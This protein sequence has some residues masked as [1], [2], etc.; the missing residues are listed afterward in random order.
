M[1][2]I[3]RR[4][5]TTFV[6]YRVTAPPLVHVVLGLMFGLLHWRRRLAIHR[7]AWRIAQLRAVRCLGPVVLRTLELSVSG[8]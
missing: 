8:E 6:A 3:R 1:R 4:E 5:R 7:R 2:I